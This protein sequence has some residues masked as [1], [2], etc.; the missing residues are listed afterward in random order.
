MLETNDKDGDGFS[1]DDGDCDDDNPNAHPGAE[2][3][4]GDGVNQDCV[5]DVF[6]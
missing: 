5:V 1:V 2:E 4:V 6:D 3:I